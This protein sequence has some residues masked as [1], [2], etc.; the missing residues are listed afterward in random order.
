MYNLSD[1]SIEPLKLV[2]RDR[3]QSIENALNSYTIL[4]SL[5]KES[6]GKE[7]R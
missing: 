6:F 7:A 1:I 4:A 3:Y 5:M 2:E